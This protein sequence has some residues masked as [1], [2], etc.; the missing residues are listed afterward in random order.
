M[1]ADLIF[2]QEVHSCIDDLKLWKNQWGDDIWL[3]HGTNHSA[4]VATLRD[5][6]KGKILESRSDSKGHWLM[7]VI[8]I[9][10]KQFVLGNIYGYSSPTL[11]FSL[12]EE[13]EELITALLQKY[14]LA[15]IDFLRGFYYIYY[16]WLNIYDRYPSRTTTLENNLFQFCNRMQI[17]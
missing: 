5:R 3:S 15:K 8:E 17:F 6:F 10:G 11:N 12:L 1:K 2:S 7:I 13:S 4:G 14:P 16:V 9:A